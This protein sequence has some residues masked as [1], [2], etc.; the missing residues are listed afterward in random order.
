MNFFKE[1][2]FKRKEIVSCLGLLNSYILLK[3]AA[4]NL[5]MIQNK[6]SNIDWKSNDLQT[7]TGF[8]TLRTGKIWKI[9]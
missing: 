2:H 9:A 5:K 6:C 3:T 1:L 7:Y 8:R 4:K